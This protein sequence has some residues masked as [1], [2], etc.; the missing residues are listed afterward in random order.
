MDNEKDK[1]NIDVSLEYSRMAEL[2]KKERPPEAALMIKEILESGESL[3]E[4]IRKIELIDAQENALSI[5]QTTISAE[6]AQEIIRKKH[7]LTEETAKKKQRKNKI[8]D[9]ENPLLFLHFQGL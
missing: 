1:N 3:Q 8:E 2:L 9:N 5:D 7:V 6:E 4:K